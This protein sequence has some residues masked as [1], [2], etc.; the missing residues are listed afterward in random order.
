ML[1]PL[2][3][4]SRRRWAAGLAAG[5]LVLMAGAASALRLSPV[6]LSRDARGTLWA[7][8]ALEEPLDDRV[9]GSLSRGMPATLEL[10]AELWRRR[11]GWFDR[12]ERAFD[13]EIR[14]RYD[15]WRDAWRLERAGVPPVTVSSL[16]SLESALR[17]PIALPVGSLD[18]IA[19]G[20]RC[21]VVITATLRP[22]DVE[23]AAQVEGWISGEVQQ[24]GGGLGV[25]TA[26]PRSVFDAVRNFAGFGDVR[27]RV[28]S[29]EFT[30]ETLTPR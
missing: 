17:R 12:L 14:L 6:G 19:E 18:R 16:D 24:P 22:L 21:Y 20:A 23:D 10:H 25:I 30:V 8:L 7:D 2:P 26:L 5:L 29:G 9:R 28:R 3:S 13:A 11:G 27:A 4:R 1:P 15:V